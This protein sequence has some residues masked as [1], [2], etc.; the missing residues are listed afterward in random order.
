MNCLKCGSQT[1][2]ARVFCNHCLELMADRPVKQGTPLHF[3]LR[4]I[5]TA[6]KPTRRRRKSLDEAEKISR[7]R[8]V[9]LGVIALALVLSL[10]LGLTIKALRQTRAELQ[11]A[12]NTGKNYMVETIPTQ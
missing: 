9:L 1:E 5:Q 11:E 12:L 8:K 3:P 10:S 6:P 2:E 4:E 7:L